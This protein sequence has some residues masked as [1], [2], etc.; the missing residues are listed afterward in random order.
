MTS[1]PLWGRILLCVRERYPEE[2]RTE[3]KSDWTRM[4][5]AREV[6]RSSGDGAQ[7]ETQETQA[8]REQEVAQKFE[9]GAW[10][11]RACVG[12]SC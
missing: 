8:S 11:E 12:K 1:A 9:R 6:G 5:W 4:A 7:R 3:R 10:H 2:S